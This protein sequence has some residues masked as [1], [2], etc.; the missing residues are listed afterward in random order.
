ME[1]NVRKPLQYS[2]RDGIGRITMRAGALSCDSLT[3]LRDA[4]HQLA[5]CRAIDLSL[6]AGAPSTGFDLTE[7]SAAAARSDL[8]PAHVFADSLLAI[9]E[10]ASPVVARVDGKAL[11]GSVGLIAACDI[12]TA[13]SRAV[14]Q[15]PEV[16]AGM[17]PALI[18]PVLARR[19]ADA[20]L[21]YLVLS[22]RAIDARE[23]H[24]IG[25]VDEVTDR[26]DEC[27]ERQI[28]RLLRSSPEALAECKRRQCDGLRQEMEQAIESLASW[29]V[30]PGVKQNVAEIADGFAPAWFGDQK[31][32]NGTGGD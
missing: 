21:R 14:F 2:A 6:A 16:V 29:L 12:V 25:L 20:R 9:R 26:L 13:S 30:Q 4:L 22:S 19:I 18:W 7:L 8:S 17:I 32:H 10:A 1:L 3:A 31:E 11:G 5:G 27:V 15:L 23:A 28:R 24:V